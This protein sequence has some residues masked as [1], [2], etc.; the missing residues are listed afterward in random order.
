MDTITVSGALT[1][2]RAERRLIAPPGGCLA[3][4]SFDLGIDS[5]RKG[6]SEVG[7]VVY[8]LK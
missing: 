6:R 2:G 4:V 1:S 3:T 7:E 8:A 5:P